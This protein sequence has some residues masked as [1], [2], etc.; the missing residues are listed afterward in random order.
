MHGFKRNHLLR[1]SALALLCL[2]LLSASSCSARNDKLKKRLAKM[3]DMELLSYYRGIN[4]RIRDL[5]GEFKREPE[6]QNQYPDR[7]NWLPQPTAIGGP[8]YELEKTRKQVLKEM[9]SRG[10]AP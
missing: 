10:L 4:D 5:D 8:I 6:R 9:E 3:T 2:F 7:E 1:A